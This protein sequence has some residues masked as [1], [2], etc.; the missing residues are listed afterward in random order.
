MR[1]P[2]DFI[3][4]AVVAWLTA[5]GD[6]FV[7]ASPEP[8]S[9]VQD[10]AR[11]QSAGD[12]PRTYGGALTWESHFRVRGAKW[13]KV[14]VTA[15][16][17]DPVLDVYTSC[18]YGDSGNPAPKY[19]RDQFHIDAIDAKGKA[20]RVTL[21]GAG[22]SCL[23]GQGATSLHF[24]FDTATLQRPQ[25]DHAALLTS[26]Y[27]PHD[28]NSTGGNWAYMHH[29]APLGDHPIS[30]WREQLYPQ[31]R[32]GG[33]FVNP[34]GSVVTE[35]EWPKAVLQN[36]SHFHRIAP[37]WIEYTNP[38]SPWMDGADMRTADDQH[39]S[40]YDALFEAC[41]KWP[42]DAGLRWEAIFAVRRA[43]FQLPGRDKGTFQWDPGSAR[44]RG[45][46]LKA[47]AKGIRAMLA[48]GERDL[49]IELAKRVAARLNNQVAEFRDA[50]MSG[51][52]PFPIFWPR[53]RPDYPTHTTPHA[54]HEC[55]VWAWGLDH[56]C[57][58]FDEHGI[59][60]LKAEV[61]FM[62]RT[63]A[64]FCF[65]A[66]FVAGEGVDLPYVVYA[67][68]SHPQKGSGGDHFAWFAA[69]HADPRGAAE[70]D[71]MRRLIAARPRIEPRFR[72]GL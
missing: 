64:R 51:R 20:H 61:G 1:A 54:A 69:M 67:D 38:K 24:Q 58:L 62:Q 40:V 35:S 23:H 49:G 52:S 9:V 15:N 18:G 65:D 10:Q 2:A 33:R 29:T 44:A 72:G 63:I 21:D 27:V 7:N 39:F 17:N 53:G 13:Q 36:G 56:I 4:P 19:I 31:A 14:A 34:D 41:E 5:G 25:V 47:M 68:G 48:I 50:I 57:R 26:D 70:E 71:K 37:T 66:F 46:V 11:K 45:R 16:R 42:H 32:Y 3:H 8:L 12:E 59:D 55:G 22:G 60:Y 6:F 28:G 30:Y 43:L